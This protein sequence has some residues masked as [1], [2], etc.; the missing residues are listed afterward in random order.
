[1]QPISIITSDVLKDWRLSVPLN[2]LIARQRMKQHTRTPRQ[3][4]HLVSVINTLAAGIWDKTYTKMK[5]AGDLMLLPHLP[6]TFSQGICEWATRDPEFV[7]CVYPGIGVVKKGLIKSHL[8]DLGLHFKIPVRE[9][10][11]QMGFKGIRNIFESQCEQAR[12]IY[13]S[14]N[15]EQ[16]DIHMAVPPERRDPAPPSPHLG[17][18]GGKGS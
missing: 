2:S 3:N 5:F 1:M 8:N 10:V 9:D 18:P 14:D 4:I 12:S 17:E 16:P 6:N 15:W 7:F 13:L 11:I